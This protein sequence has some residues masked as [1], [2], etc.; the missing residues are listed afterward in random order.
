MKKFLKATILWSESNLV[1]GENIECDWD[2]LGGILMRI[3]SQAHRENCGFKTKIKLEW[4]GDSEY[5]GKWYV[6]GSDDFT[7]K[8]HILQVANYEIKNGNK[9]EFLTGLVS[10]QYEGV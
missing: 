1:H 9:D 4:E 3:S 10:G 6:S 7:L 8:S 5:T 2:E